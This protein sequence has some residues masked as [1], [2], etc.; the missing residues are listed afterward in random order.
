MTKKIE[1]EKP[2]RKVP[3]NGRQLENS[4]IYDFSSDDDL[5]VNESQSLRHKVAPPEARNVNQ[6]GSNLNSSMV[7]VTE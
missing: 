1:Y 2:K 6:Q 4:E 5:F 3:K 7:R